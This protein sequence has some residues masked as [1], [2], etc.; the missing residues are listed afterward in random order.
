MPAHDHAALFAIQFI[1]EFSDHFSV[2]LNQS[3]LRT[4]LG[5]VCRPDQHFFEIPR[6]HQFIFCGGY[7]INVF[8]LSFN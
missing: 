3:L 4:L 2:I 7:G 1:P 8:C 6:F 5:Q